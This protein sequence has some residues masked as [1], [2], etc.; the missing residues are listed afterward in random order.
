[1]NT[2]TTYYLI[3]QIIDYP[4]EYRADHPYTW[5]YRNRLRWNVLTH[6]DTRKPVEFDSRESVAAWIDYIHEYGEQVL[7]GMY[8]NC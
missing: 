7:Q 2:E 1:M 5:E 4:P 3:K 8:F 6:T